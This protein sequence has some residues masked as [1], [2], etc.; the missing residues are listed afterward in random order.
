LDDHLLVAV[1]P[2]HSVRIAEEFLELVQKPRNED[3]VVRTI[4]RREA[5]GLPLMSAEIVI[6]GV[7]T[8]EKYPLAQSYPLHFRKTYFPGRLHGDPKDEFELQGEA[9]K[10]VRVSAPIGYD[11]KS[12]RACLVPGTPF[13]ALSPFQYEPED[14]PLRRAQ[15]LPL[16]TAAGLWRLS[17]Q[18]FDV[19]G[20]L[21]RGG[22]V[23]GD[24]VLQNF[25]VCPSP[26]EVVPIDF[27]G[28]ARRSDLDE[29]EWQKRIQTD[30]DP[31]LLHAA[32]VLCSLGRQPEPL[33]EATLS[34][35]EHL[36]RA[37]D[38]LRREIERRSALDA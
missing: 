21:H 11:D 30:L 14:Q 25:V 31:L 1:S 7:E 3:L 32:F 16:A 37:P 28:S 12:F 8:R 20:A 19:L 6:A 13:E 9:S 23:H 29:A 34:R 17:V 10:L 35:L 15:K 24:A 26:L 2:R 27:E 4:A 5:N 18:A 22:L 38:R 36:V 33:A